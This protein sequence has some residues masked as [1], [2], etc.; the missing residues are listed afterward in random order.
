[1]YTI[2]QA[3][4]RTGLAIP[5]IRAW[6]R[7]Y[8]IVQPTRTA[9]GYRIYDDEAIGRLAA[10]RRLVEVDGV[11]PSQAA[12]EVRSRGALT[13]R[14]IGASGRRRARWLARCRGRGAGRIDRDGRRGAAERDP[15]P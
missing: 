13:H 1:M 11:R 4:L 2:K 12:D 6:E 15:T 5:T 9:G 10:M 7:R 3:A 8:G 14:G